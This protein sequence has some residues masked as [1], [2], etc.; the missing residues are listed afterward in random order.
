MNAI[1]VKDAKELDAKQYKWYKRGFTTYVVMLPCQC[2][3]F[4]DG[5]IVAK[6]DQIILMYVA[7]KVC[8]ESYVDE[9]CERESESE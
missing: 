1:P 2:C 6:N 5:I 9:F 3:E 7:C 4:H 8:N